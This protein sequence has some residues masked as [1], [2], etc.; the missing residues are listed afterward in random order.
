MDADELVHTLKDLGMTQRGLIREIEELTGD[1]VDAGTIS[2]AATGKTRVSPF[3]A[4]YLLLKKRNAAVKNALLGTALAAV[5][6]MS[7]FTAEAF[8][9]KKDE[10]AAETP[11]G[12]VQEQSPAEGASTVRTQELVPPP[13]PPKK[14][15]GEDIFEL[16][17]LESLDRVALVSDEAAVYRGLMAAKPNRI[18]VLVGRLAAGTDCKFREYLEKDE[19]ARNE[20]FEES[21]RELG[22]LPSTRIFAQRFTIKLPEY[23]FGKKGV[24]FP[25]R[26]FDTFVRIPLGADGS[27]N[28]HG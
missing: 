1:T 18:G 21:V 26:T 23:D 4:A 19:F 24:E 16:K 15:L 10:P 20:F 13:A 3:L 28:T 11:Q 17:Q 6:A 5:I 25:K 12:E 7:P 9:K 14:V 2:R 8:F 27:S 22:K